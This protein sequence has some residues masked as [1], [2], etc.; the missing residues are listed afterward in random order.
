MKKLAIILMTLILALPAFAQGR[1]GKDSAECV[2]YLSYYSELV[3]QNNLTEA[4]PFWRKAFSICPPTVSQNMYINGQKIFRYEIGQNR[5]DPVRYKQ[6]VDTLLMLND[7]RAQ[8]YPKN[9]VKSMD[10]K[11][12]DVVNYYASDYES[13]FKY[14]T[15]ILDKIQGS[16]SPVV[17]VTQMKSA[18]D[19]PLDLVF[20][21][22]TTE[23]LNPG[24]VVILAES[25]SV[26]TFIRLK[27]TGFVGA[28]RE[29]LGWTGKPRQV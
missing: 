18:V 8:Y 15:E 27:H 25:K 20:D 22:R 3:K 19:K 11:A 24:D 14:L 9:A 4:A 23:V 10:N 2:K 5:K 7:M 26:T 13:Q 1:Y 28:L 16:A 29:K 17:F 21:G 6:L 12:I